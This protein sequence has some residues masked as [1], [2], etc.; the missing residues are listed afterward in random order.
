MERYYEL[1]D[2]NGSLEAN[3]E[4]LGYIEGNTSDLFSFEFEPIHLWGV[5]NK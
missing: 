1:P 4:N 2:E 5:E 3:N